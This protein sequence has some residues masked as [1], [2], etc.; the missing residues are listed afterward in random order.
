MR[1]FFLLFVFLIC[2]DSTLVGTRADSALLYLSLWVT[3]DDSI[4]VVQKKKGKT[5]E[6]E[7]EGMLRKTMKYLERFQGGPRRRGNPRRHRRSGLAEVEVKE[8]EVC[9]STTK[10]FEPAQKNDDVGQFARCRLVARDFTPGP[11]SPRD[12]SLAAML[13][14]EAKKALFAYVAGVREKKETRTGP[15]RSETHVHRLEESVP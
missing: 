4:T 10:L 11:E 12:D 6:E 2:C 14:L 7:E 9:P 5:V 1:C 8:D 3:H 13:P 15:G